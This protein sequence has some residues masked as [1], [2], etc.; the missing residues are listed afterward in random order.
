MGRAALTF[1]AV[2]FL[3]S[4]V[5]FQSDGQCGRSGVAYKD[6]WVSIHWENRDLLGLL[7]EMASVLDI[8]LFLVAMPEDK[9]VTFNIAP[10]TIDRAVG[11]VLNGYDYAVV[12]LAS[13]RGETVPG[14]YVMP[15]ISGVHNPAVSPDD[16]LVNFDEEF[17][18]T[19]TP[20]RYPGGYNVI[21][22]AYVFDAQNGRL[23]PQPADLTVPE[24]IAAY[25]ERIR[26]IQEELN[27]TYAEKEFSRWVVARA[28][29][30]LEFYRH[31][32]E[33]MADEQ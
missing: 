20:H 28:R 21:F 30:E 3:L 16:P 12:Y 24:F 6:G 10:T 9:T 18:Q 25:E 32:L 31:Q 13:D 22:A 33:R 23:A 8:E 4:A 2:V 14:L 5:P 27:E 15:M 11:R 19:L 29:Q 7:E 1:T 17:W 26:L